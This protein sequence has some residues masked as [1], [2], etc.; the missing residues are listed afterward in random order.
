MR[1]HNYVVHHC[2]EMKRHETLQ[3]TL[4]QAAYRFYEFWHKKNNRLVPPAA[5]FVTSSTFVSFITFAKF[6]KTIRM[7]NP[8]TYIRFMVEK[9][10]QP[11]LWTND[12]VYVMFLEYVD[13]N[14]DPT[15]HI[16]N[17]IK[18]MYDISEKVD[19]DVKEFFQILTP[20]EIAQLVRQRRLSP[21]VLLHCVTFRRMLCSIDEDQ[22]KHL[23]SVI[24]P[25]FWKLKFE[26]N[27]EGVKKVKEYIS[28]L[29]I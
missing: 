26:S 24:R 21:W 9:K 1:E 6:V 14:P 25:S 18:T 28:A 5:T 13:N 16:T 11:K 7:P 23:E 3:T 8:R 29:G 12:D 4:G 10:I 2:Q 22:Q 27:P 20:N 15:E 17:T 19:V